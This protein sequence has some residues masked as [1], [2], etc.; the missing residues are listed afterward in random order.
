[1]V[2]L[3]V[4]VKGPHNVGEFSGRSGGSPG[5]VL[6]YLGRYIRHPPANDK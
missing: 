3:P 4:R 6:T 2:I 5:S 1:M